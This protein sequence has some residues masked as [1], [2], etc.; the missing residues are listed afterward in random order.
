MPEK[1]WDLTNLITGFG[2][3]QPLATTF[4][5]IKGELRALKGV[6]AHRVVFIATIL[7]T[8]LYVGAIIWCWVIGSSLDDAN[9]SR[10]WNLTTIG[11]V[12][13]VLIFALVLC[14]ALWGHRRDET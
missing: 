10:I 5:L 1:L 7:F 3:L 9:N 4:A 11:R 6:A 8:L 12:S 2:V 14:T 13:I